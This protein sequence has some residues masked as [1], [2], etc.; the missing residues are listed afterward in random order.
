MD[1]DHTI[2]ADAVEPGNL[3][4]PCYIPGYFAEYADDY[5]SRLRNGL[6][7][8][9]KYWN[10]VY[11]LPQKVFKYDLIKRYS[12]PV[13]VLEELIHY[14]EQMHNAKASVVW[15]NLFRN[16]EDKI[17]WHQDQYGEH[18]TPISFGSD[19]KFQMRT[20]DGGEVSEIILKHGDVYT[21]SP[22][23]DKKFEHCIPAAPGEENERI[24]MVVWTQPPG[25][26][27]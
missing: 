25:S 9:D 7:W 21:W 1:S 5:F 20:L 4:D 17:E 15:C 12:A 19:R 10:L 16:G 22:E 2:A 26:G 8:K 13:E 6:E 3:S 18:L 14:L 24:S 27:L 11:K 23:T